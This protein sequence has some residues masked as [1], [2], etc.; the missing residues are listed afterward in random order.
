MFGIFYFIFSS[1]TVSGARLVGDNIN[2]PAAHSCFRVVIR[3]RPRN[4]Y[5]HRSGEADACSE[6]CVALFRCPPSAA[7]NSSLSATAY[8]PV[9][10]GHSGKLATRRAS[11]AVSLS[12]QPRCCFQLASLRPCLRRPHQPSLAAYFR[13]ASGPKLLSWCTRWFTAVHRRTLARSRT[14]PTFQVAEYFALPTA[15][16]S[17]NQSINQT[18]L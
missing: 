12:T 18:I 9:A 10:D 16:T 2:F 13:C 17:S 1:N 6:N 7:S 11:S 4:T 14:M 15:T 8:V 5:W 3:P